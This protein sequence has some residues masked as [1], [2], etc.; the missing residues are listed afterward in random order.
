[1]SIERQT[2]FSLKKKSMTSA[3][4]FLKLEEI[5]Q[6]YIHYLPEESKWSDLRLEFEC[7]DIRIYDVDS[8]IQFFRVKNNLYCR[9]SEVPIAAY[10]SQHDVSGDLVDEL[11]DFYD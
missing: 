6:E 7:L 3:V 9:D 8:G 11:I 5:Q 4:S 2:Y 10:I 1:M